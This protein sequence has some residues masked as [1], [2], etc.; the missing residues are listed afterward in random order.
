MSERIIPLNL[1]YTGISGG[2]KSLRIDTPL[3]YTKYS[4]LGGTQGLTMSGVTS[5][6]A[7]S[8][9]QLRITEGLLEFSPA[10]DDLNVKFRLGIAVKDNYPLLKMYLTPLGAGQLSLDLGGN[11]Q[12]SSGGQI[13]FEITEE[14]I[15]S[16]T[17]LAPRS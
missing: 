4:V 3:E 16:L 13:I 5:G 12:T 2:S 11:F 1:T 9:N 10:E 17:E 15:R 14:A 6:E 7:V 8:L